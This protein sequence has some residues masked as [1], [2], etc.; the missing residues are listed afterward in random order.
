[1]TAYSDALTEAMTMLGRDERTIFLGQAVACPG[2]AMSGTLKNVPAEKL[3]EMPVAEEMQM[4]MSLGLAL[5]GKIP[6]SIY[7]RWNFLLLAT[8]QLVN[9]LDKVPLFSDYRPTILIRVGI[10]SESP[11]D[12]GEQHV[13][14]FSEA[15]RRMLK[16]IPIINLEDAAEVVSAYELAVERGGVTILVERSALYNE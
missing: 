9:H 12:P 2:T 8:N 14:D 7:P 16:T 15:F 5:T 13:G 1:M 6:I 11:L 4:G 10:G 3:L